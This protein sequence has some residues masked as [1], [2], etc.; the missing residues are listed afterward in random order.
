VAR[1]LARHPL[2]SG[3]DERWFFKSEDAETEVKTRLGLERLNKWARE[4]RW[5]SVGSDAPTCEHEGFTWT[6][7]HRRE[8]SQTF[9]SSG[10]QGTH[11]FVRIDEM[12]RPSPPFVN[13][14]APHT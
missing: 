10:E 7:A 4:K 14:F 1:D 13:P 12:H 11:G 6:P 8:Y 9:R 2:R 5:E 3:Q